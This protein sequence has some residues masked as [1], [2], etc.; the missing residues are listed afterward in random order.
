[1]ENPLMSTILLAMDRAPSVRRRDVNGYLHV[2]ISNLSKANV[3]PYYG[4]EIPDAAD[5]GLEPERVYMLYRDPA[6][7]LKG[8][9]TFNNIPLLSEHVPV[10]PEEGLPEDLIIGS[11]G[12]DAM[13]AE[14]YLM[15]SLVV[16]CAE[17]Q[18]AIDEGRQKELSCGYRYRA[19][20]TAGTTPE[21]LQYDGVMREIMGNHVALVIEGRAGPDVVIGDEVMKLKSRTALMISGAVAAMIRPRLAADAKVDIAS[22][23][24]GIDAKS[25]AMDGAPKKLAAKIAKLV[26]PHLAADQSLDSDDLAAH[27]AAVQPLALDEDDIEDKQAEDEDDE[28]KQAADADEDDKQAEDEDDD[29]KQAEDDDDDKPAMD[30]ATVRKLISA[31][32]ARGAKRVAAIEVAKRDVAPFVGEVVGLDSADA[33][34]KLALDQAGVDLKGV[35]TAAYR[36]MVKMLPKANPTQ[37]ANDSASITT[38]HSDFAKRFPNAAKLVRS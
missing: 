3:C 38:H 22:A 4:R 11:T 27:I 19:D 16:W 35:P 7:L 28:D 8:A 18:R 17:Y 20:M 6:E 2:E 5:L 31:A 24:S 21:G 36:A 29:D 23:L 26:K 1:M 33:V 14:P 37:I 10:I 13:F 25:I 30:A 34:Y 12:T 32:E 15:N 9:D